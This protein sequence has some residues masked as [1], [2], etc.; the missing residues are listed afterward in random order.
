MAVGDPAASSTSDA[1]AEDAGGA[2]PTSGPASQASGR[3]RGSTELNEVQDERA[4]RQRTSVRLRVRGNCT[5]YG[6]IEDE[7]AV[8]GIRSDN[9]PAEAV[10][11]DDRS[12]AIPIDA[13]VDTL[14]ASSEDFADFAKAVFEATSPAKANSERKNT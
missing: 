14:F 1:V 4:T 3:K 12:S 10:D 11:R 13:P 7:V 9:T 6:E 5:F 8:E 2:K